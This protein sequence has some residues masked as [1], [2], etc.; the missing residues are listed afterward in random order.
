MTLQCL[1]VCAIKKDYECLCFEVVK[2]EV[3]ESPSGA[4]WRRRKVESECRIGMPDISISLN[5][6]AIKLVLP[7]STLKTL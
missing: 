6:P 5:L 3:R 1:L 7:E 2:W 4:E